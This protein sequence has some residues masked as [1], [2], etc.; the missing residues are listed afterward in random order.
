MPPMTQP[1]PIVEGV[2]PPGLPDWAYTLSAVF[3]SLL[4]LAAILIITWI[5]IDHIQVRRRG[6]RRP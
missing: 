3:A 6:G 2:N 4:T 1:G 5:V